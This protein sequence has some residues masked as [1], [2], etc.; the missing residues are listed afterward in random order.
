MK[1]E[2]SSESSMLGAHPSLVGVVE[3]G[4]AGTWELGN[5]ATSMPG[6]KDDLDATSVSSPVV[7]MAV[8]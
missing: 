2:G 6:A 5:A 7:T 4:F 8:P 3:E 1:G